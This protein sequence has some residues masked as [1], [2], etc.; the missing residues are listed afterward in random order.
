MSKTPV[1][2]LA[3]FLGAGKTTLLNRILQAEHGLRIAVLVN[4]FGDID[5]DS[6]LI[7]RVEGEQISLANGCICCTIREDLASAVIQV[8][9]N[10]APP[11]YIVI[12]ASGVSDPA[13]VAMGLEMSSQLTTR[14]ALDAIVT[15]VDAEQIGELTNTDKSLAIDQISGADIVVINKLDL[16]D[17][18][19]RNRIHEWIGEIGPHARLTDATQ[20]NVPL[21]L[22]LGT[23]AH[24]NTTTP[25]HEPTEVH[26]HPATDK[27]R[28]SH[29]HN[30]A[31]EYATWSWTHSEPLAFE[32]VYETFKTL[33]LAVFRAK[34]I[35]WL[36][37]VPDKRVIAQMVG[38]RVTLA[39]GEPWDDSTRHSQVVVI[40][41]PDGVAP[42]ALQV[43]FDACVGTHVPPGENRMAAAVIEVLRR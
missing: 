32:A 11:E 4:D 9:A 23:D 17:T 14:V 20:A 31:A 3:G 12:E 43:R 6:Q 34:G 5:I 38:K 36:R 40:G 39:R 33:P 29:S 28:S 16:V 15:I 41:A 19:E 7:T 18:A 22:I 2:I 21:A 25:A 42:S 24:A 30:H 1:T 8:L 10:P 27:P 35:L 37:E 13:A 26:V